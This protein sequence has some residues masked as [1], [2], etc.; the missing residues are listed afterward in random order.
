MGRKGIGHEETNNFSTI[1]DPEELKDLIPNIFLKSELDQLEWD[2]IQ[3][4]YR[5]AI[6][7]RKLKANLLS[8]EGLRLLHKTMFEQVWQWAGQFRKTQKNIGIEAHL[9]SDQLYQ[10]CADVR[11]QIHHKTYSWTEITARFHHRLV[12]IHPFANGNGRHAR[13]AADLLL[14]YSNQEPLYW[15]EPE[16]AKKFQVL[17]IQALRKADSG[18]YQELFKLLKVE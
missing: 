16:T 10:L 3:Q 5:W 6:K 17:Y 9:I 18:D 2:N 14:Y 4:A 7:S 11:Y 8:I 1:I 13:L 12:S 15:G